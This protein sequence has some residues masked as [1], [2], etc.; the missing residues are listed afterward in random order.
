[1][2]P[3]IDRLQRVRIHQPVCLHRIGEDELPAGFQNPFHFAQHGQAIRRMKD[4]ILAPRHVK[5]R[6]SKRYVVE[7][8]VH[9]ADLVRQACSLRQ[10][11]VSRVFLQ[12]E[13]EAG[14]VCAMLLR[15]HPGGTPIARAKV[16]HPLA[17]NVTQLGNH[18]VH[19]QPAGGADVEITN[20]ALT[21]HGGTTS[22][23]VLIDNN[24][25]A[26][27]DSTN[28]STFTLDN[29]GNGTF[30]GTITAAGATLT[31][32][33]DMTG[34]DIN[35]VG[36]INA[37]AGNV[38]TVNSDTVNSTTVNAGTVNTDTVNAGTVNADTGNIGTVNST[39]VNAGTVNATTGNIAT[40]NSDTVNA[41][42][43]NI[44][45]VNATTVNASFGNITTV[46]STT[47]N[48]TGNAT[49][50]SDLAV[51]GNIAADGSVTAGGGIS[52]TS[53]DIVTVTGDVM[54]GSIIL[55]SSTG[56]VS[57][58]SDSVAA[59]DVATFGQLTSAVNTLN[60][61]IDVIDGRVTN[62]EYQSKQAFQGIAMGFAMNAAPLN[63]SNGEGG[64]SMG[65]GVFEGEYVGAIR[66]QFVTD[67]GFGLGANVGFSEDAVGGG[68]GASIKF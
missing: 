6:V 51:G 13:V 64:I 39:T 9:H 3:V 25:I 10:F 41:T 21:L 60:A 18:G 22:T 54:A 26:V 50:G 59:N 19:R 2:N 34:N 48:N 68:I 47:I 31:G 8:T 67:S 44:G 45:T 35:N 1:V 63:L 52:T 66:A 4:R 57:G 33:L 55:D 7:R 27:T 17:G 30:A 16:D 46:N 28:G 40:V 23:N 62:L 12:R 24:G 29:A 56:R 43:G 14:D 20:D 65:A 5:F 49:I 42:T 15:Q 11:P 38:G 58:V 32:D 37:V 61:R 53:G 36:T